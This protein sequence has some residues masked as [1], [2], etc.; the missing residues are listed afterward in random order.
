MKRFKWSLLL[1]ALLLTGSVLLYAL[2]LAVFRD[3]RGTF[4]E[5]LASLAFAPFE[6][7][8]VTLI[9]T[10]ILVSMSQR[11]KMKKLNMVIGAF[12]SE[13]GTGLLRLL[14]FA[15]PEGGKLHGMVEMSRDL[16]PGELK[17][18]LKNLSEHPF[19]VKMEKE[20]L[21]ALRDMLVSRRDFLVR[22]LENPNLLENENFTDVLWAV[23]HTTEELGARKNLESLPDSD[24]AHIMGDLSRAYRKLFSEWVRYMEHLRDNYPFL[25]SFAMRTNPMEPEDRVEVV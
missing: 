1:G 14:F 18:L 6:T 11:A 9:I 23:F 3:P 16:S 8:I 20:D 15:D 4:F 13:L 10:E 7:L 22:L 2:H 25:F 12:F 24:L 17:T 19:R 21:P 5:G